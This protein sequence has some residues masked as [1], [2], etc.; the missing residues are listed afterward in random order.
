MTDEIM[1][2]ASIIRARH[3]SAEE[4]RAQDFGL[5][6]DELAQ[7]VEIAERPDAHP[8]GAEPGAWAWRGETDSRGRVTRRSGRRSRSFVG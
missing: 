1:Q 8:R 4:A 6:A 2:A 3:L 5:S 7:A